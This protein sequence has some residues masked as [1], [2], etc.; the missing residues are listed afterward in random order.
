MRTNQLET[1]RTSAC[2]GYEYV[3]GYDGN[4]W[5]VSC[6]VNPPFK[7]ADQD[8]FECK[9]SKDFASFEDA[10]KEYNRFD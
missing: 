1:A 6:W 4:N 8:D 5:Q 9:W 3:I 10:W 2:Q 7:T